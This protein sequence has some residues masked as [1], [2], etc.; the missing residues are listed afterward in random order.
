MAYMIMKKVTLG[1]LKVNDVFFHGL[2]TFR[3]H[4]KTKQETVD[5]LIICEIGNTGS[6][7]LITA[8][9]LVELFD[10]K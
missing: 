10:H 2:V 3:V 5:R 8:A 4:S 7:V 1:S 9:T 6:Y